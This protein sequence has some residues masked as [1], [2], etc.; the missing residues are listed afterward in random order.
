MTV[1]KNGGA[2]SRGGHAEKEG[3]GLCPCIVAVAWAGH[4]I[5][6]SLFVHG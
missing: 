5:L 3:L 2:H 4:L 6:L 1:K